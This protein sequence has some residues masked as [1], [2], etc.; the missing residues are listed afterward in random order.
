MHGNVLRLKRLKVRG[1]SRL[2]SVFAGAVGIAISCAYGQEGIDPMSA[3]DWLPPLRPPTDGEP[4]PPLPEVVPGLVILPEKQVNPDAVNPEAEE[5]VE[6]PER[7]VA[8]WH[9]NPKSARDLAKKEEKY[10]IMALL[11]VNWTT[12]PNPSR[13]LASEILNDSSF[14]NKIGDEFVLSYVDY[15]QNKNEWSDTHEKLK[16]YYGVKGFPALIFFDHEGKQFGKLS[17]YKISADPAERQ[18]LFSVEFDQLINAQKEAEKRGEKRRAE[19]VEDGYR[20]WE[21]TKGSL[22]FAKLIRANDKIAMFKDED[23]RMRRVALEQLDIADRALIQ[24]MVRARH[25]PTVASQR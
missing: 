12:S 2:A 16:D 19:L 6:S 22:L 7:V 3:P 21:S 10:H 20:E 5:L 1:F 15:P 8:D 24:R 9:T 11:G 23:N 25:I 14:C 18:F 17:G 4:S 13:L